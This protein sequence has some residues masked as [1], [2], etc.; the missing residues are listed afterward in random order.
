[1]ALMRNRTRCS[2]NLKNRTDM[3]IEQAVVEYAIEYPA[4]EQH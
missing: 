2:S 3:T 1:M 4:Y